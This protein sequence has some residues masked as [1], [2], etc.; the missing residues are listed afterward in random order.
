M[1][2]LIIISIVGFGIWLYFKL[3]NEMSSPIKPKKNDFQTT[4]FREM[5]KSKDNA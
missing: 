4:L 1:I 2:S 5:E 3:I